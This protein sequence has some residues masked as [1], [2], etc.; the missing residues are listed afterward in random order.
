MHRDLKTE[1]ILL[2]EKKI[3]GNFRIKLIDFGIA[4]IAEAGKFE[5]STIGTCYYMAPEVIKKNYDKKCDLWSCGVI[6]YIMLS[7]K[8][9]FNGDSN[10]EIFDNICKG[11]Y[12]LNIAPFNTDVSDEAKDLIDKLLQVDPEKRISA[13]EALQHKWFDKWKIKDKLSELPEDT[14]KSLINNIQNY[15][16]QKVLQQAALAYIVH[17]LPNITEVKEACKLFVKID[18]NLDGSITKEE[19]INGINELMDEEHKFEEQTL[20]N[21]FNIIDSDNSGKIEYEEFVRAAADKKVLT[22]EKYVQDAFKFFDKDGSGKITID[23]MYDLFCKEKEVDK[24]ELEDI[25]KEVDINTDGKVDFKEF[26]IMMSK[27]I[28]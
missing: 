15:K 20:I 21:M 8:M 14:I 18:K 11:E 9:P 6:L 25:I 3:K 27:I 4:Q 28:E 12:T 10:K 1:N 19:F 7:G 17:N 23:E 5:T 26:S 16:P 24:K 2:E 13:E 22:S